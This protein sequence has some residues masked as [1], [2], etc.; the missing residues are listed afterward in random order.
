MHWWICILFLMVILI[1]DDDE[2]PDRATYDAMFGI[3]LLNVGVP[4]NVANRLK[5]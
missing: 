1:L 5:L 2:F 4:K 3:K